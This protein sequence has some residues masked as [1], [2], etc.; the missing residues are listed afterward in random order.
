[1][2][3]QPS[4]SAFGVRLLQDFSKIATGTP[5]LTVVLSLAL[6]QNISHKTKKKLKNPRVEGFSAL[7]PVQCLYFLVKYVHE[8]ILIVSKKFCLASQV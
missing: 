6:Q 2:G 8:H 4:N 3:F 7:N 5:I 1:M